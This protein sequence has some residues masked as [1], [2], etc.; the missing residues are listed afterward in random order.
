VN[1]PPAINSKNA[2]ATV[3]LKFTLSGAGNSWVIDSQP[4]D[5]DTLVPTGEAPIVIATAPAP[6]NGSRYHINWRTDRSW[7]G[8]CRKVTLRIPA[9][10]DAVA[11][12]SFH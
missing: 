10:S 9:A 11:Y 7:E 12:F 2:G 6:Q 1:N 8:T 3:P 4:I 5:C